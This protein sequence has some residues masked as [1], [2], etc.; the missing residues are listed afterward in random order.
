[1]PRFS[2]MKASDIPASGRQRKP[3]VDRLAAYVEALQEA[4]DAL[5]VDLEPGD[6]ARGV[7]IRLQAAARRLGRRVKTKNIGGTLYVTRVS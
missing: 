7:A 3:K 1:M 4:P 6:N 2:A 5:R